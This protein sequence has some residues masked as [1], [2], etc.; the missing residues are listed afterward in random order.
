[1]PK[2]KIWQWRDAPSRPTKIRFPSR[3]AEPSRFPHHRSR[4]PIPPPRNRSPIR[5]PARLAGSGTLLTTTLKLPSPRT[6]SVTRQKNPRFPSIPAACSSAR[7][8]RYSPRRPMCSGRPFRKILKSNRMGIPG[9]RRQKTRPFPVGSSQR[10]LRAGDSAQPPTE[11]EHRGE[12]QA[13]QHR[14]G[15]LRNHRQ[16]QVVAVT[17]RVADLEKRVA[18]GNGGP[19]RKVGKRS[20]NGTPGGV[21]DH[22]KFRS[23]GQNSPPE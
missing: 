3:T 12:T 20:H 5:S 4:Q 7:D 17:P 22:H 23:L 10:R 11:E 21:V 16:H 9:R 8:R 13:E 2:G 1:M 15:R 6:L 14:G 19:I 18:D